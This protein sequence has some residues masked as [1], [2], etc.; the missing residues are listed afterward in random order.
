MARVAVGMENNHIDD[1]RARRFVAALRKF[2]QDSDPA[3][4]VELFTDDATLLRFDA[5]GERQGVEAFWREYRGQFD[6]VRT[7]F[8]NVVEGSDQFALEWS[9]TA[10]LRGGRSLE[11]RGV[12]VIDLDGERVVRLRTYY[13]SAA[14]TQVPAEAG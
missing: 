13:D 14:F 11:Y 4:L 12:T 7:T 8:Y 2:E 10:T 3:P 5:R 9:S 6:E 1:G